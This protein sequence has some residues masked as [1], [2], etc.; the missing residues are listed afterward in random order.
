MSTPPTGPQDAYR[1][2]ELALRAGE[3]LLSSGASAAEVTA[4]CTAVA[5]AGGLRGVECDI[6]FTS[7]TVSGHPADDDVPVSDLRLVQ[8]RD[9]DYTRATVVHD[10]VGDL[11]EGR[12]T[13]TEADH[14]LVAAGRARQRYP[15][16]V[17][18]C[19]RATLAASVAVLLGAGVLVT[20]SAFGATVLVG[21]AIDG[22]G[23]RGLPAFFQ[24][25]VGGLIA[26]VVALALVAADLGVRPPLVIA[27]GIVL[28]LPGVTLVGAVH[29]AITGFYV[30]ASARAFETFLLTAGI[31]SGVAVGLSLGVRLGVP[32]QMW[33]P[34]TSGLDEVPLQ[35]AA[36]A[37][38]SAAF[39]VTYHAPRR[40]L[41]PAAAAGALG[42]GV[43]VG[44]DRLELSPT[45]A[46]A[47]AAVVI[48]LGSYAL[49]RRQRVPALVYVAAGIIPLLPG[50]AI[51]RGLRRLTE[52]DT[53]GGITL[54]GSAV[55][56]GLALAAGALL[57][58][59]IGQ[60]LRR[61]RVPAER[62]LTGLLQARPVRRAQRGT[63]DAQP[64]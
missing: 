49:A 57:G 58:E 63:A 9:L 27:G 30:T 36:A 62:R 50:L 5:R 40:T 1:A 18:I 35:L 41:L 13:P 6:T 2:V 33:E 17:V 60:A 8:Q 20:A 55:T 43:F 64:G 26:T 42:W 12:I 44:L 11:T 53:L 23:R 10:I 47:G 37:A 24:N 31:I 39:A 29:D 21:L 3:L 25:A 61:S 38:I 46:S 45:L 48:G 19:A 14:R 16:A 52:G 22:L 56:V 54:L 7:I 28:L 51:Y 59:Y 4:T 34:A 32:V 15:R